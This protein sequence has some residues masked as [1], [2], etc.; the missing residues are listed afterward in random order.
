MLTILI[1]VPS[2][3]KAVFLTKQSRIYEVKSCF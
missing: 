2:K 1:I 3:S